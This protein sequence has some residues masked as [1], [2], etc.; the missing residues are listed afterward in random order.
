MHLLAWF[1]ATFDPAKTSIV[2]VAVMLLASLDLI[3]R[4]KNRNGHYLFACILGTA[5]S[6]GFI[7]FTQALFEV[8]ARS[9]AFLMAAGIVLLIIMWRL[10][11]GPWEA[12]TKAT[13]L[14][15]FVFWI[16]LHMLWKESADLRLAHFIAIG[17][18]LIPAAVWCSLFLGYHRERRSLVLLMF[19]AGM[20]STV[21]ILFYDALARRGIELNFFLFRIVPE[22]FGRTT[23]KFVNGNLGDLSTLTR[24]LLVVFLS[25]LIVGFIEE[26][27]KYWVFQKSGRQALSSIDDAM[28]LA[29]IVAIGFA[30]AENIAN[31]GYFPAFVR[32]YLLRPPLADWA[33]F[34]G[35]VL[36]RSILTSM[37]HIVSTGVMGY[38]FG[39][40]LFAGPYL[41]E[42][43]A[44]GKKYAIV[45]YI[46]DLLRLPKK[47][48][49]QSQMILTG[50]I[51]AI[52][53]HALSN[54]LVTLPDV[55]PGNP[56]TV[57]DLLSS[58][59][60]SVFNYVSILL[61]PALLY[62]VGGFWLLTELFVRKENL[63]ERGHV[64]PTESFVT[65]QIA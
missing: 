32:D 46:H 56:R 4:V 49:F 24:S 15:T 65:E 27:S 11:F 2:V 45:E 22:S 26:V 1:P 36:G 64:I 42:A 58:P 57:G 34:F 50:L 44:R 61:L 48:I 13:V 60:S 29:I 12:T 19:F 37:V 3:E 8:S 33:G 47:S 30:F 18:A 38:F 20:L 21:P 14:G 63:K 40:A 28:Q 5:L 41:Q 52:F 59:S 23:E 43:Q 9:N 51:L 17:V 62:V 7:K 6:A 55:L 31:Q 25:F 53:L 54:F 16:T 39:L 35:N 10:L